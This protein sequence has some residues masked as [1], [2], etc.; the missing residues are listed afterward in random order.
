MSVELVLTLHPGRNGLNGVP[1]ASSTFC[2]LFFWPL[3]PIPTLLDSFSSVRPCGSP[4]VLRIW[5]G[6]NRE[7]DSALLPS[8]HH[9]VFPQEPCSGGSRRPGQ[10][11]ISGQR[12]FCVCAKGK[13]LATLLAFSERV[14]QNQSEERQEGNLYT[15]Y[16]LSVL[17]TDGEGRAVV[18]KIQNSG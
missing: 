15:I 17:G 6:K 14:P 13:S 18:W 4:R 9:H 11:R 5:R 16:A 1:M 12:C 8:L 10:G 7:N 2:P 3:P